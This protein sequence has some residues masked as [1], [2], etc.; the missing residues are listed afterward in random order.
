M[1]GWD[2][3][4]GYQLFMLDPNGNSYGY[5]T[6]ATGKGKQTAKN[7]IEKHDFS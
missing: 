2:E 5:Y 3:C 1:G 4:K 7:E 6:V